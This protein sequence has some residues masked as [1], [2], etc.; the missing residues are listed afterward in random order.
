[1]DNRTADYLLAPLDAMDVKS[2]SA[3]AEELNKSGNKGKKAVA[4]FLLRY[5]EYK[6][7]ALET[8]QGAAEPDANRLAK[9]RNLRF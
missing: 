1:M 7:G 8:K 5:L 3:V 2:L 6:T 9:L 4:S